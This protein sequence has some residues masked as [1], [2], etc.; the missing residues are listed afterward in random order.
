MA[1][2]SRFTGGRDLSSRRAVCLSLPEFLLRAL[3]SRVAEANDGAQEAEKVTLEHLIEIELA[4]VLSLAEVANLERAM[5]GI[6]LAVTK[7]LN[8]IE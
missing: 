6:S 2:I 4:G 3:E 5:P 7:W 8:D 1:K